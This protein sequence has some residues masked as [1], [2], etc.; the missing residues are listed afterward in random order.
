MYLLGTLSFILMQGRQLIDRTMITL[1]VCAPNS[2]S[3]PAKG[4]SYSEIPSRVDLPRQAM[5]EGD[6]TPETR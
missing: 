2:D 3:A 4:F 1:S 5:A 6:Q